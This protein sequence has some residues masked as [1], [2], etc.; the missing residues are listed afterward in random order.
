MDEVKVQ[1]CLSQ[2]M[3]DQAQVKVEPLREYVLESLKKQHA[4]ADYLLHN[5]ENAHH[6]T[7]LRDLVAMMDSG[8]LKS[9]YQRG[10]GEIQQLHNV[11]DGW[12]AENVDSP[13]RLE[14]VIQT[15][16]REIASGDEQFD[17]YTAMMIR[18]DQ[19]LAAVLVFEEALEHLALVIKYAPIRALTLEDIKYFAE[20]DLQTRVFETAELMYTLR[21]RN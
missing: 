19:L 1:A 17:Y 16:A 8:D 12:I 4:W 9:N 14:F 5:P 6:W 2:F 11:I 3:S 18:H 21:T 7:Q 13:V 20:K 15:K 10:I